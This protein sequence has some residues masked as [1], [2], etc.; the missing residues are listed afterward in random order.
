[1]KVVLNAAHRI[2]TGDKGQIAFAI[3]DSDR[4]A[5]TGLLRHVE[6]EKKAKQYRVTI[7]PV[8]RPRTTGKNSQNAYFNGACQTIAQETG[9][10]FADV[11]LYCKRKAMALGYPWKTDADDHPLYSLIDGEPI[12]QSEAD[13]SVEE[14]RLLIEAAQMLAA[15]LGIL[16]PE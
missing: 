16:L 4:Y 8:R 5:L 1:M 15:E 7:E 10:D 2:K 12:P 14:C 3:T 11:K 6:K 13:A 9:N